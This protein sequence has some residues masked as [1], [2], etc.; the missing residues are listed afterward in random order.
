MRTRRT[1]QGRRRNWSPYDE[2]LDC[3]TTRSILTLYRLLHLPAHT[4]ALFFSSEKTKAKKEKKERERGKHARERL[5]FSLALS[6]IPAIFS[7]RRGGLSLSLSILISLIATCMR[8]RALSF[9]LSTRPLYKF[10]N[11]LT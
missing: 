5:Y 10:I 1:R 4:R 11:S 2:R 6:D 9:S 3:C 8:A 7:A